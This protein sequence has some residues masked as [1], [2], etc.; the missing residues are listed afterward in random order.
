VQLERIVIGIDFSPASIDAAQWVATHLAPGSELVLTHVISNP[1][2]P[3]VVR[4]R[5]PRRDLLVDTVYEGAEHKLREIGRTLHADF[6]WREIREGEPAGCL[7][8]VAAEFSADLVV[9]G[10]RGGRGGTLERLGTTAEHLV[11]IATG[12]VLVVAHARQAAPSRVLVPADWPD[13]AARTFQYAGEISRRFGAS[14][15]GLQG[16][17]RG[18]ASGAVTAAA[19]IA[20]APSDRAECEVAV[21]DVARA[22][23]DT[24]ERVG[25][26]LIVM[27]R[28][29]AGN[30]RR[31][32]LGSVVDAMLRG[33]ACPVLVVPELPA[34]AELPVDRQ[35]QR[36][37]ERD[38]QPLDAPSGRP[39]AARS[40]RNSDTFS[41]V[42][43]PTSA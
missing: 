12:P 23:L 4:A 14:V 35:V 11:R 21:G 30:L 3:P 5:L 24:A 38:G 17:S 22:N 41:A 8:K 39:A 1:E 16:V 40:D 20:G 42:S 43:T 31:A 28:Q 2:P 19:I 36:H 25:A 10:A 18:V 7:T 32:S 9:V 34:R 33:A 6:V 26:D 13:G 29:E 37:V 15:T 27:E